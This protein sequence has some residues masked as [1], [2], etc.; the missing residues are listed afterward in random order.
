MS[1]LFSKIDKM[2]GLMNAESQFEIATL[3]SDKY[4]HGPSKCVVPKSKP[5]KKSEVFHAMREVE[6]VDSSKKGFKKLVGAWCK[7]E[8]VG[9]DP[10][11][12][13]VVMIKN[14]QPYGAYAKSLHDGE[15]YAIVEPK[16]STVVQCLHGIPLSSDIGARNI[17][18]WNEFGA[19][20]FDVDHRLQEL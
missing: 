3:I 4:L 11:K 5:R 7:D 15:K 10:S 13:Y 1:I 20:V 9:R 8:D 2:M 19:L 6:L 18:K 12:V 14:D 17:Y 16:T